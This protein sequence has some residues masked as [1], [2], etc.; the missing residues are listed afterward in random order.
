[1]ADTQRVLS[2]TEWAYVAGCFDCSAISRVQRGWRV[3]FS[4]RRDTV[5]YLRKL[6]GCGGRVNITSAGTTAYFFVT[7]RR[8]LRYVLDGVAPYSQHGSLIARI[9]AAVDRD[10]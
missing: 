2:K 3:R 1:M 9:I 6:L 4:G 8:D 7:G 10:E 5:E